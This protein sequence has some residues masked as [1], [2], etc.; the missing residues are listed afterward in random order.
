MVVLL[1][2]LF[3]QVRSQFPDVPTSKFIWFLKPGAIPDE[4][5]KTV[6]FTVSGLVN[7]GNPSLKYEAYF[8]KMQPGFTIGIRLAYVVKNRLSGDPGLYID[9]FKFKI[10]LS[11]T[12]SM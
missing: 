11:P 9:G 4:I 10:V 7:S 12:D 5:S 1:A 2:A 3:N 6:R 8:P